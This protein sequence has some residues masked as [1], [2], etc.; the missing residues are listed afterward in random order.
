MEAE[1]SKRVPNSDVSGTRVSI[2]LLPSDAAV[3]ILHP[4]LGVACVWGVSFIPLSSRERRGGAFC[5]QGPGTPKELS[6]N[7]ASALSRELLSMASS[8]GRCSWWK[9]SAD[10]QQPSHPAVPPVRPGPPLS[11]ASPT[12]RVLPG[13]G[14]GCLS[15]WLLT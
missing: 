10:G 13:P 14:C 9:P 5:L 1:N 12:L 7:Q 6:A 15:T 4:L 11:T 8:A 2:F 3:S